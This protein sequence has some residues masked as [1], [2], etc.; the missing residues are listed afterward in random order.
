MEILGY[1]EDALT[2]WTI[3]NELDQILSALGDSSSASECTVFFRPSFGRRGGKNSPQFGEFDFIILSDDFLHLGESK[4]DRS[5][6]LSDSGSLELRDEQILRHR[7]FAFYVRE[8][9][10]RQYSSWDEFVR[11]GSAKL[12]SEGIEKPLAPSGSLLAS[13]LMTVL[14]TIR[15]H[16]PVEPL[17]TNVLLYLYDGSKSQQL[18]DEAGHDFIVVPIDCSRD[19]VDNFIGIEL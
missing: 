11:H 16:F 2:L 10:Y 14:D 6:E 9:A 3:K 18:P 8:W 17:L 12:A 5:P 7:I 1:G 19:T 13:N 15:D 4:W